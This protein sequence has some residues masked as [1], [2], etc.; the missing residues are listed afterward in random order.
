MLIV[1]NGSKGETTMPSLPLKTIMRPQNLVMTSLAR[2]GVEG[3][4]A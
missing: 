1:F 2:V 3:G 4:V